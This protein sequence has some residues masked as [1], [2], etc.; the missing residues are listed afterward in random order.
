MKAVRLT[1]SLYDINEHAQQF[2]KRLGVEYGLAVPQSIADCWQFYMCE[3]D[4]DTLPDFV[5]VKNDINPNSWVGH[6][7]SHENAA[8]IAKWMGENGFPIPAE[9]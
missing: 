2:M 8:Q 4:P 1:V 6:G 3:Y 7:L 9:E 5:G